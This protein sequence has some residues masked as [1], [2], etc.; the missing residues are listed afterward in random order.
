M[1][2]Q[3]TGECEPDGLANGV[4]IEDASVRGTERIEEK[5]MSGPRIVFC[6][7]NHIYDASLY[8]A[9]PYCSKI[10]AEQKELVS[11]AALEMPDHAA[12]KGPE[13]FADENSLS[14]NFAGQ[15]GSG[16]G[17]EPADFMGKESMPEDPYG[18]TVIGTGPA[19]AGHGDPFGAEAPDQNVSVA[20]NLNNSTGNSGSYDKTVS[21]TGGLSGSEKKSPGTISDSSAEIDGMADAVSGSPLVGGHAEEK[22]LTG[23][24][25]YPSEKALQNEPET[26]SSDGAADAEHPSFSSR[27]AG[28]DHAGS[29]SVFEQEDEWDDYP[30]KY[31]G[32]VRGWFV[33][34]NGI[35]K[36]HS[37]ELCKKSM[38]IYDYDGMLLVISRQMED[39]KL[40]ATIEQYKTI[41]ILPEPGVYF[42]VDGEARRSCGKLKPYMRLLIGSH[43][44]VYVPVDERLLNGER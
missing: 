43:R 16:F 18:V 40:L 28:S 25:G 23:S 29:G 21:S 35:Q 5:V 11:Q 34:Q 1:L 19:P 32:P 2:R 30:M 36:D 22:E 7:N 8:D 6:S 26:V 13:E 33:L 10:E 38:F 4:R 14:G 15:P 27:T 3:W 31:E 44:M 41:S 20:G 24:T 17:R 12:E 42:E 9:C 37:I 39:M